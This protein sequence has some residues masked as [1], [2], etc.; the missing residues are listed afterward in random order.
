MALFLY[1][2]TAIALLWLA[3]HR[4]HAL[5]RAA[6]LVLILLPLC[7]TGRALLTG[8]V[9]GPVDLP[10]ETEPLSALKSDVGIGQGH[11]GVL[12]DLYTQMIPW[13]KAVQYS[14]AH[15]RWPLW[16]RFTLSGDILAPAAQA[17]AYSPL[18]LIAC[19]LPVAQSL[20]FTAAIFFFV[21]GLGAFLLARDLGCREAA[22]MIAAA[23][24]MYSTSLAFF[25]LWSIGGAWAWFLFVLLGARRVSRSPSVDSAAVLVFGF[26]MLLLAG[27]PETA[28]HVVLIAGAYMIFHLFVTRGRIIPATVA[29][30]SAG[31]L[32]LALCAVYVLPILEAAPQ[33]I[34]H[35][36]R[37]NVYSNMPHGLNPQ[38]SLA[39]FAVDLLPFLH[40]R[41]WKLEKVEHVDYGTAG[42]GSIVLT[43]SLYALW[44][45]KSRE[46]PFFGALLVLG[47]LASAN[48]APLMTLLGKLPLLDM[49]LNDRLAYAA[50]ASFSILA[51]LA[52]EEL[53]RREG[54]SLFSTISAILLVLL[55]GA[56]YWFVRHQF[57]DDWIPPW[58]QYKIA[59]ELGGLGCLAALSLF[60]GKARFRCV[61]PA[62]LGLLV[63]QRTMSEGNVYPTIPQRAAYPH[64]PL[65]DRLT[66]IREPFR[67][68]GEGMT[69]IPGTS[70]LY[71][72]E[73]VRGYE[74]MTFQRYFET[75]AFW[76]VHQGV[77]FNRVDDLSKPFLSFLNVRYAVTRVSAIVPDGW[78]EVARFRTAKLLE[79]T[80]VMERAFLPRRVRFGLSREQELVEMAVEKD[81]GDRAWIDAPLGFQERSNGGG[82]IQLSRE[83]EGLQIAADME[84]DG[85]LVISEPAW[86]GWRTY[87][88][89][90]RVG[91]HVANH[92][93]IGV[94]VP[95]GRHTV[96]VT[97]LPASF[98]TGRAITLAA[99]A[100]VMAVVMV[101]R[102]KAS[103]APT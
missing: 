40:I 57:V 58:G 2:L 21:S 6:A 18:T 81:F 44:R 19:L 49:M 84:S 45:R 95:R 72:L 73:D 63:L 64:M 60:R 25:I 46:V 97:F 103:Q 51:A 48:W 93:F 41:N 78:H 1:L 87:I 27:H 92:A 91:W 100:G 42:A 15:H 52:V 16:N 34:E 99:I 54:D 3:H 20:T 11:N 85:W 12:S 43:L 4:V 86:S 56:T 70:A 10:Y 9:Y 82:T 59:A 47:L 94:M 96:R 38:E 5:T 66:A 89:G 32:A 36:F 37:K 30:V 14:Y 13:R 90:R 74:A 68:V 76:C 77:F 31:L 55:A 88:D 17:A 50:A 39:H 65:F 71:E 101:R 22:A 28:A 8:A 35:E 75:Y 83:G 61:V 23:G 7:F 33:T 69:L 29:T 53:A 102:A 24:W 67:I 80:R 26:T 79:N 62:I 98:V